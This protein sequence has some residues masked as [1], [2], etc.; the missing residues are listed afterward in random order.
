MK[1]RIEISSVAE[2]EADEAFLRLSQTISPT[3][4]KQWYVGL[5]QAIESLSQMP[6]RSPLA[7]ENKY[8]SQEIRQLLYGRGRNSYRILF[9]ILEGQEI[10]T[11]RILH[12]RHAVQQTLGE[13]PAEPDTT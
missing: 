11:V 9:T 5:L 2:A 8:F 6:K 13:D 3:R 10:S 7:R 4:A 1:Y 12:I